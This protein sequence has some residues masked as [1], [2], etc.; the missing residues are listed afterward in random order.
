MT[1]HPDFPQSPHSILDPDI[2][3]F[4]ADEALSESSYDKLLPPLVHVLRKKVKAWRDSGYDGASNTSKSLL[5]WWFKTEH[6]LPKADGTTFLFQYYFAQREA[7]ETVIYL[8]DVVH[9]KDKKE[10]MFDYIFVDEEGFHT[11]APSSFKHLVNTFKE[12]KSE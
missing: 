5:N 10:I 7:V 2:R 8:Y 11:Y 4:P 12:Y 1:I 9:V 6:L 3:W